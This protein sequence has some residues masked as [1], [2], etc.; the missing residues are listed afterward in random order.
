MLMSPGPKRGIVLTLD[1]SIAVVIALLMI[2]GS[3]F[4]IS[5]N[6]H[7]N[8]EDPMFLTAMDSL[9]MLE[10]NGALEDYAASGSTGKIDGLFRALPFEDCMMLTFYQAEPGG[11]LGKLGSVGKEGCGY[12]EDYAIAR[13]VFA[14]EGAIY[15]AELE[16]WGR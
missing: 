10:K 7:L 4:Y 1:A 2:T 11:A 5:Q 6:S 9:A 15:I 14:Y 12:P 3:M 8:L 13:R 16:G